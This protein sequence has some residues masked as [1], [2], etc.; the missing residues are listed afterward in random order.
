M[1]DGVSFLEGS[2]S[3][4]SDTQRR[5]WFT[6]WI[7]VD[8]DQFHLLTTPRDQIAEQEKI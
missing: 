2:E 5:D 8:V 6:G 7:D 1:V 4:H 3:R